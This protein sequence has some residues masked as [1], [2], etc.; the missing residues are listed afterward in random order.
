MLEIRLKVP[1]SNAEELSV[2]YTPGVAEPCREIAK[3]PQKAYDYTIKRNTVAVVTDGSA[4]LGLGNIGGL[5]GLPVMEGKCALFKRFADIDAFP[6]CLDTQNVE[7]II[8]TVKNIAPSFGGINL[9]DISAP[10]CF[11]IERRLIG[12]LPI[13]VFHDD[14]HG[15]AIVV[16]AALLN[17]LK[18]VRK[19]LENVK[20]VINGAGAAGLAIADFL[21]QYGAKHAMILD[22]KGLIYDGR[23]DLNPEKARLAKK[24]NLEKVSGDLS[25]ALKGADVFIGIS[26][27]NLVTQQMAR[28]MAKDAIIFA[29]AN[30]IPEIMPEDAKKAGVRIVAT[31]RSD[32]P[33]QVNNVLAFPGIFRGCFDAGARKITLKM[34]VSAAE[35][36]ARM[37]KKPQENKIIPGVFDEGVTAAVAK[38]V[39]T[40]ASI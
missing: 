29:M 14:Q 30:P 31:G 2:A 32:Y 3:N 7:E 27:G 23:H 40:A 34:K 6:I 37:I 39:M 36:L 12:E 5:A 28:S 25:A 11:E 10:R 8:Q 13:P 35:A 9:E 38:A 24:T 17:A 21:L 20:I 22:T 33:N 1:L 15:T 26:V 19:S 18:V 16:L 4:V